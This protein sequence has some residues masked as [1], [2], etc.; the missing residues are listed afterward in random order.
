M[1]AN[2]RLD[3]DVCVSPQHVYSEKG[4]N[5]SAVT[6]SEEVW[7]IKCHQLGYMA[8]MIGHTGGYT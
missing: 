5:D 8:G 4:F 6:W 2:V 7:C 3:G 1:I